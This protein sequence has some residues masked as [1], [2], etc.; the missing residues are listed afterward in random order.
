MHA[1]IQ[2]RIE[3]P[4]GVLKITEINCHYHVKVPEGKQAAAERALNV[5]ERNCP[6][7]QTLKGSVQI[8]NS[9]TI[10]AY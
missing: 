9:W 5:F 8:K 3:A 4:D 6:V 10:E 2:G 7:A 1:D